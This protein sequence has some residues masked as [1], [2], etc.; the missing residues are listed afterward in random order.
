MNQWWDYFHPP[1]PTWRWWQCWTLKAIS[2]FGFASIRWFCWCDSSNHLLPR[3]AWPLWRIPLEWHTMIWCTSLWFSCLL[4][5]FRGEVGLKKTSLWTSQRSEKPLLFLE[6]GKWRMIYPYRF[7]ILQQLLWFVP[8]RIG[9]KWHLQK[10]SS[11]HSWVTIIKAINW[12]TS[13]FP[14]N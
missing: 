14:Y 1:F 13:Y 12:Y 7:D 4:S 8:L 9:L 5:A 10:F 6:V 2:A 11:N 3:N